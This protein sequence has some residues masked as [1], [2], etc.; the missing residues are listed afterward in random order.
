MTPNEY[1]ILVV[2]DDRE[3]LKLLE[4]KLLEVGYSV[5]AVASGQEALDKTQ[6]SMPHLILMDIMLPGMDGS[7][8]VKKLKA[9]PA[10]Q[11]IPIVFLSG[12]AAR[13][14]GETRSEVKCGNRRFK[15]IPK[16]FTFAQLLSEIKIYLP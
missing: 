12:I 14:E 13:V 9:N 6:S 15:A 11:N 5:V 7:E 16:P 10:T 8:V 3:L 1:K 4:K 2:E